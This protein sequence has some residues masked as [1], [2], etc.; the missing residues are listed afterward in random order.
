MN[1]PNDQPQP[2]GKVAPN[3]KPQLR[4]KRAPVP[5]LPKHATVLGPGRGL[6]LKT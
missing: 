5:C 1:Q 6:V 3:S 2:Q 4:K